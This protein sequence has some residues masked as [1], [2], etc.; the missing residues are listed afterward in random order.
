MA[1]EFNRVETLL[2]QAELCLRYDTVPLFVSPTNLITKRGSRWE[3]SNVTLDLSLS[4]QCYFLLRAT[5][6]LHNNPSQKKRHI[7]TGGE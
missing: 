5:C 1:V 4:L 2:S 6:A 3:G 7:S